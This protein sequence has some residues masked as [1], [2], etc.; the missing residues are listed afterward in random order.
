MTDRVRSVTSGDNTRIKEKIP[1]TTGEG[2]TCGITNDVAGARVSLSAARSGHT[3][4]V[5]RVFSASWLIW[6]VLPDRRRSA[7]PSRGQNF[8]ARIQALFGIEKYIYQKVGLI[9]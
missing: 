3:D 2:V 1:Q 6:L 4:L 7:I 5:Y 9:R 8:L